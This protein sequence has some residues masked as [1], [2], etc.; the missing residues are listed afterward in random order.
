MK[1]RIDE[2]PII[3]ESRER[4]GDFEGDTIQGSEKVHRILTHVERK[5]GLLLADKVRQSAKDVRETA[6]RRLKD[7]PHLQ[8]IT[9]DN[10]LEFSEHEIIERETKATIYFAYPYHSWERGANENANGLLRQFFPKKSAFAAITQKQIDQ[11]VAL[12]NTRPRK[13]HGYQTPREIFQQ[14]CTSR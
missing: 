9:Y 10:G 13:R 4:L 7:F 8:T 11:A 6:V 2:R 3:V 1:R 5:S 14:C 12:I